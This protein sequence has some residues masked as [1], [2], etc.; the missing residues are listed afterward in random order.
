MQE[1]LKTI[2]KEVARRH[3]EL[4]DVFRINGDGTETKIRMIEIKAGQLF[5]FGDDTQV[6]QAH[7]DGELNG[8]YAPEADI[9]RC[10]ALPYPETFY[11]PNPAAIEA[12]DVEVKT[13]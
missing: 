5:R 11:P 9:G 4:R 7:T 1:E 12:A 10:F 3:Y 8:E 2:A 13:P 6:F